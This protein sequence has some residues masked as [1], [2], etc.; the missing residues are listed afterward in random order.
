MSSFPARRFTYLALSGMEAK[1]TSTLAM[2]VGGPLHGAKLVHGS[3]KDVL[4]RRCLD[5]LVGQLLHPKLVAR[6]LGF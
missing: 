1:S 3:V 4:K 6:C 2:G 5:C